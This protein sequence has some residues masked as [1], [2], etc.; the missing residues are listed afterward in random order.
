MEDMMA[1][2]LHVE[3]ATDSRSG[4][5]EAFALNASSLRDG[6]AAPTG[7]HVARSRVRFA[8]TQALF[9]SFPDLVKKIGAEPADQCPIAFLRALMSQGKLDA[10]VAFCAYL[11]PRREAVWWACGCVRALLEDI[12]RDEAHGLLAAEAWVYDPN[13]ECRRA[14]LAIGNDGTS[15]NPLTWLAL[16]AGWSGGLLSAHPKAPRPMPPHLTA[17]AIRVAVLISAY[18]LSKGQRAARLKACIAE[19]IELAEEGL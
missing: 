8:T 5:R 3:S 17:Q 16:A 11:L 14:A 9:E 6:S 4:P 19:G 12:P 13:D 15:G 10:A 18:R 2:Q 1:V 7:N